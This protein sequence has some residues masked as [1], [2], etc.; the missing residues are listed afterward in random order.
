[1][2]LAIVAEQL[3]VELALVEDEAFERP[4]TGER[5]LRALGRRAPARFQRPQETESGQA[6]SR[7]VQIRECRHAGR[8][9]ALTEHGRQFLIRARRD[10]QSRCSGQLSAVA[11]AAVAAGAALREDLSSSIG[12]L[13]DGGRPAKQRDARGEK[14][15]ASWRHI[16]DV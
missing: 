4:A 10:A 12:R 15:C 11:V 9:K 5:H 8:R 13:R 16:R 1:M 7:L 14:P 2:Q 6:A 3:H